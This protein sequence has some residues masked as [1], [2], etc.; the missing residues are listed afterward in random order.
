MKI[1]PKSPEKLSLENIK[2]IMDVAKLKRQSAAYKSHLQRSINS[3]TDQL[4]PPQNERN[5]DQIKQYLQQID[6]KYDRWESSMMK[7][8]E[9]PDENIEENITSIDQTLDIVID[10]RVR[11]NEAITQ[12]LA[13][14]PTGPTGH[15][16]QPTPQLAKDRLHLPKLTFKKF[17]GT[18][19]EY[20]QEW[21]QFFNATIANTSMT[22]VEKFI[23]LKMALEEGSEAWNLIDGYPILAANYDCAMKDLADNY[24]DPQVVINHHVSKLLNLP[25]QSKAHSLRELYNSIN[26]HVR[27][28]EGLGIDSKQYSIFLVPIV[29]SKLSDDLRKEMTRKKLKDIVDLIG[30]LKQEVET[31]CS[32]NLVKQAFEP[33]V[34]VKDCK[35]QSRTTHYTKSWSDPA[36]EPPV[37]SAQALS[38]NTRSNKYC[39]FCPGTQSH[40]VEDCRKLRN[41]PPQEV[42]QITMKENACLGCFKKGHRWKDCRSREK[43]KC[44]KCQS[45]KHHTALHE[46]GRSGSYVSLTTTPASS[47]TTTP[48]SPANEI[49]QN[50]ATNSVNAVQTEVK[51]A[52]GLHARLGRDSA[53]MPI[54]KARIKG[55]NGRKLELNVVMDGCS[56][57]SFIRSDVTKALNLK[58]ETINIEVKGIAGMSKGR[59]DREFINTTLYSRD[60]SHKV[61]VSFLDMPVICDPITRPAVPSHILSNRNLR[62][63]NFAD[64]YTKEEV[65][66][67]H[68]LIGLDFYYNFITG[69][70]KRAS[71]QPVAIETV[72]GWMLVSDSKNQK[73]QSSSCI[74]TMFTSTEVERSLNDDLKKFWEIEEAVIEKPVKPENQEA[75]QKF[76]KS[77]TYDPS[78]KKYEVSLPFINDDKHIAS[79]YKVAEKILQ[80]LVKRFETNPDLK[81]KYCAAM[82]EYIN[83]GFAELVPE[84]EIYSKEAGVYYIPHRAVI[85]EENTTTKTRIV[86]NASSSA[87]NQVCLNDKLLT[88]PKLQ[89]SIVEILIRWRDDPVAFVSDIKK[90]YSHIG[91]RESDRDSLRFLWME[92]GKIKH[93]R[94]T[95][96]AFGLR[97]APYLAIE[98]VQSHIKKFASEHPDMTESLLDSTYVDDY[99]TSKK[100]VS[101]AIEAVNI[102][103]KIM[104]EAGMELRKWLSNDPTVMQHCKSISP[105]TDVTK[106]ERK[107]LGVNWKSSEDYLYYVPKPAVT[108]QP[109]QYITKRMIIGSAATL[110]DPIGFI[111]PIVIRAKMMIQQL[112]AAGVEWDEN[113][114]GTN[115]ADEWVRWCQDLE[116]L[117]DIRIERKYVPASAVIKYREV[118]IFND[119]SEKGYATVAYLRSEDE[120][121]KI[122]ISLVTSKTKVTPL[123][124]VTLPRLELMSALIG[125]RISLRIKTALK[126]PN[127]KVIFWLDSTIA[128]HWIKS[129]DVRWK[130]FVENR[131]QEIRDTTDPVQWRHCPGKDNPADI[132]SRG[133]TASQLKQSTCWWG[134]PSW[135]KEKEEKWP[136]RTHSL[137]ANTEAFKEKRPKQYTCLV[138]KTTHLN[139][140]ISP[141]RY[142]K[143]SKLLRMTAYV[144]RFINN[145][146][147]KIQ[148][149]PLILTEVPT[150]EEIL[151]AQ[152]YWLCLVQQEY[153]PE[154]VSKLTERKPI[155]RDSKIAQLN[156]YLDPDSKLLR[157]EGRLQNSQLTEDEKHP[158]ILPHQSHIVK[159]IVEDIHASQLHAGVNHVL[160]TLRNEFWITHARSLVKNVVHS[161]LMCRRYMPRR[162]SVPMAPLP[163]DRVTEAAPFEIIGIDFT[164]PVYVGEERKVIVRRS[165]RNPVP[166][167][168]TKKA[169]KAYIALTTCAITRAIHLELVPDLST[170]TFMRSFRRFVSRRGLPSVIYS[171]NAKTYKSGEKGVLQCCE[172]LNRPQFQEYM[173][174]KLIKWKYICPLSPW[175]GGYWERLMRTIKIPLK[176]V[177]GKS[178]LNMDE[179]YT[180]LTE[181]EAMVNSRPI[182]AVND[183][184]D[185]ASY[186]TPAN[187]LIGRTTITLPVAPLKHTEVHPTA[188]RKQLNNMLM[189]QEKNLQ[190]VWKL[191]REEYLRSLGVG[192]SIKDNSTL[193]VGEIV[194]VASNKQP[195]CTWKVGKIEEVYTGRDQRIRSALVKMNDKTYK[196]PVQL[197]SKLE[198]VD[199]PVQPEA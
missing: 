170:D 28:L 4:V 161:C 35:P 186:L 32:A 94:H 109:M 180:V 193:K 167:I 88:G 27:S 65:K 143:Y 129:N 101:E 33:E 43:L 175:W 164:G 72:F 26:T 86:N 195:R 171:D 12:S 73:V 150:A 10:M 58:G 91:V 77:V 15:A 45:T 95:V 157:M 24:G 69:R 56:D 90:M 52:T 184:P 158:I 138:T 81:S 42:R 68:I 113:L 155:K 60:F 107:V 96:L 71:N 82:E 98:T 64:D 182:C 70:I 116:D 38:T 99:C 169:S 34:Q 118:H 137:E 75:I 44:E 112:W 196:R 136:A 61:D 16:A 144:S 9:A 121:G 11:A 140:V 55:T 7:I 108:Q 117:K 199:F 134:G 166:V 51:G 103:S 41:I 1:Q 84:D 173:S 122:H 20:F 192:S 92:D 165:K 132:S 177:L 123:K 174:E 197:L 185:D 39:I 181:I 187:F 104:S 31:E 133:A 106:D 191:W 178:F 131:V 114:V 8:Q 29:M 119:A 149:K 130:T 37:A 74:H 147:Q 19:I 154:E 145:C 126:D 97:S 53:I 124:V 76:H 46:E 66:E 40:W 22:K 151:A 85:K 176:K 135:L 156:P 198:L 48:A 14:P 139:P 89:P 3:L 115:L 59:A 128:L 49:S 179:L 105:S 120:E 141:Q 21:S 63:L 100:T 152:K 110:H 194:M 57:Q 30:E 160:V 36:F 189:Y 78:T 47:A 163:A 190:K 67:I 87:K 50:S 80:S 168:H 79:N 142:S 172:M 6:S 188:T 153:Y 83:E 93:Y 159:L 5:I 127:L 162:I 125:S 13:P 148:K 111:S 25:K 17:T 23:Y 54:M 18:N 62:N 183:D 2:P 102:S 146:R